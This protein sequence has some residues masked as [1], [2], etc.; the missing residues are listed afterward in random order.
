MQYCWSHALSIMISRCTNV[1]AFDLPV[2]VFVCIHL[3]Q[4]FTVIL[5]IAYLYFSKLKSIALCRQP[6]TLS[7]ILLCF[8]VL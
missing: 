3:L 6:I 5:Y 8:T 7:E 1:C 2:P 4:M